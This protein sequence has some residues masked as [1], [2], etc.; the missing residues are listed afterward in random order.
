MRTRPAR[1]GH[2]AALC[3]YDPNTTEFIAAKGQTWLWR[4]SVRPVSFWSAV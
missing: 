3:D 4:Q 2:V 1:H